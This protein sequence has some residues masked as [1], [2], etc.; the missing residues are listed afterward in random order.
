[1]WNLLTEPQRQRTLL[2]L[3]G[4]VVRHVDAPPDGQEVTDERS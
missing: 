4:I 1:L 2:I 3:S